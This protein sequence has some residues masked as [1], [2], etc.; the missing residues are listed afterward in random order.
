MRIKTKLYLAA[1]IS[2]VLVSTLV[3]LSFEFSGQVTDDIKKEEFAAELVKATTELSLVTEEYLT[4]H[5]PRMEA[6]WVSRFDS[7]MELVEKEDASPVLDAVRTDLASL[8]HSFSQLRS[9][10]EQREALIEENASQEEIERTITFEERLAGK[11]RLDSAR[12]TANA[13]KIA[14]ESRQEATATQQRANSLVSIVSAFLV[15]TIGTSAFVIA[16]SITRPIEELTR[17]AEIIG[18]GDLEHRIDITSKDETGYLAQAFNEMVEKRQRAEEELRKH[19]EHLEELVEERTAE[20][21]IAKEQAQEADR[22]KSAFLATMSHELRTP[23]NSI[24]GF[25]GIILRGLV[26]PLNDEQAKQLGM[27]QGSAHHL[28]TLINDVLDISKIE[29]GQVEI[30]TEPFDARAAIEKVVRTVTPLAEKKGLALV[31]E[32]APEVDQ[33]TSD[34][35]RVEQILINLV[36]NAIK[37]TEHGEVRVEC[38]VSD[39]R[40]VT[41]VVDTGIGIKPEDMGKLFEAFRQVETGLARRREGT[42]LGLSICQKLVEMLGGEIWAESEWGVGSTFTFTLPV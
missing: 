3:W 16:R 24:I 14:E 10:Y 21:E 19:R 28:L 30:V 39:R 17:G 29:A 40:L 6:Q 34:R 20:L 7:T 38:Q 2:A 37:F 27:V 12:I 13:L 42:G 5:L 25:T 11:M 36:N 9:N 4:Y 1:A 41:R 23:L 22:L 32:V 35:R 33:I 15:L 26:G 8:N 18:K 31:A